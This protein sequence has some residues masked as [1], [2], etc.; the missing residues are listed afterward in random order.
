MTLGIFSNMNLSTSPST[1]RHSPDTEFKLIP[2]DVPLH[3]LPELFCHLLRGNHSG[4]FEQPPE[5]GSWGIV[6]EKRVP[7]SQGQRNK[8]KCFCPSRV[9]TVK[10]FASLRR[11]AVT[12]CERIILWWAI[13][14]F[15]E[16]VQPWGGCWLGYGS[17]WLLVGVSISYG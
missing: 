2:R 5:E 13:L 4:Q 6:R 12:L 14:G 11:S 10:G 16:G 7:E 17:V 1:K 9:H 15:V 3:A 8:A